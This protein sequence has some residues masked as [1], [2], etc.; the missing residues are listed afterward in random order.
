VNDKYKADLSAKEKEE[1]EKGVDDEH[2]SENGQDTSD[3]KE[4]PVEDDEDVKMEEDS[5][6]MVDAQTAFKV[7]TARC[8]RLRQ[9]SSH[10]FNLEQFLQESDRK[11]EIQLALHKLRTEVTQLTANDDREKLT[12]AI[13]SKYSQGLQLLE[14]KTAD[15]FGGSEDMIKM[16][17]LVDNEHKLKDA[18][19]GFCDQAG[20]P[21]DATQAANV[22]DLLCATS[23]LTNVTSANT[24]IAGAVL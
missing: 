5:T 20:Y 15:M 10:P 6:N 2:H 3:A 12:A 13:S 9:L 4:E 8:L 24:F 11:K 16:V 23:S 21:T 14:E 7:R 22:S 1:K 17:E 18:T 19:C